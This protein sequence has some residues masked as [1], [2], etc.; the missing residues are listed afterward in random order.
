VKRIS[1]KDIKN[2]FKW[3]DIC[4]NW[5]EKILA[6]YKSHGK[7]CCEKHLKDLERELSD[8]SMTQAD[9]IVE[10]ICKM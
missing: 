7:K 3:C 2:G 4:L 10:R 1:Q 8:D 6:I 5:G 9:Y